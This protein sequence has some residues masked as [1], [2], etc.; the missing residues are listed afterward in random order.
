MGTCIALGQAAGTAA[1]MA[2]SANDWDC[3]LRSIDIRRLRDVLRSQGA[4]L[5]GTA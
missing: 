5:E 4:I 3:D 1:A 2:T